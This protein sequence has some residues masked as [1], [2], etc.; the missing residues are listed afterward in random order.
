MIVDAEILPNA[1]MANAA[2]PSC[3][4]CFVEGKAMKDAVSVFYEKL[5]ASNNKSIAAIPDD[6]FYYAR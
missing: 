5:Y 1:N 6:G 2:L 3:N 4:I